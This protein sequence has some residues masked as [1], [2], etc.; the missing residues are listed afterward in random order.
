MHSNSKDYVGSMLESK[1]ERTSLLSE[2]Q[3]AK[4]QYTS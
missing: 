4:H 3:L 2:M 1:N